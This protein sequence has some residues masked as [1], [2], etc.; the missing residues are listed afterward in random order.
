[1]PR[2]SLVPV[3]AVALTTAACGGGADHGSTTID[4]TGYRTSA[5]RGWTAVRSDPRDRSVDADSRFRSTAGAEVRGDLIIMRRPL[6]RAVAGRPVAELEREVRTGSAS[7]VGARTPAAEAPTTLDGETAR[8]WTIRRDQGGN[9]IVQRQLIALHRGA[10]YTV[11]LS[12]LARDDHG[13]DLLRA[14]SRRWAW[15]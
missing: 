13:V 14:V 2:P 10:L 9:R 15:K 3:L 7:A 8:T 5:P 1:V 11:T 6:P 4:G 12:T